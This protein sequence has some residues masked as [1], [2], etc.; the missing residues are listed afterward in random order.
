MSCTAKSTTRVLC[1]I[2]ELLLR[3]GKGARVR[4]LLLG[5]GKRSFLFYLICDGGVEHLP[6]V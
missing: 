1:E 3:V 6:A 4:C 2:L 5:A